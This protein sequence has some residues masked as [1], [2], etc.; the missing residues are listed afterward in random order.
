MFSK[1][2]TNVKKPL[3]SLTIYLRVSVQNLEVYL[4][5]S[6]DCFYTSKNMFSSAKSAVFSALRNVYESPNALG[7]PDK[8]KLSFKSSSQTQERNDGQQHNPTKPKKEAGTGRGVEEMGLKKD[9]TT[10]PR[11]RKTVGTR[12]QSREH[13]TPKRRMSGRGKAEDWTD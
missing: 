10:I 12:Y 2:I 13:D 4:K 3:S 11:H 9:T 6:Y 5:N 1:R 8:F 7:P